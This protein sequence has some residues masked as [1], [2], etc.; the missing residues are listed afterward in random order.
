MLVRLKKVRFLIKQSFF[1]YV[2]SLYRQAIISVC[3]RLEV[4]SVAAPRVDARICLHTPT[5]YVIPVVVVTNSVVTSA[6]APAV[7][8]VAEIIPCHHTGYQQQ[9]VQKCSLKNTHSRITKKSIKLFNQIHSYTA[10][11]PKVLFC[12]YSTQIH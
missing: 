12:R 10:D 11:V 7:A 2:L 3:I 4:H 6:V 9:A 1:S 5:F 8:P